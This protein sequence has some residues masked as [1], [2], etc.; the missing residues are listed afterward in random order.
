[1]S[2]P[3]ESAA[4]RE[5]PQAAP[6][7]SVARRHEGGNDA[8]ATRH[9]VANPRADRPART[10]AAAQHGC[11]KRQALTAAPP[12]SATVAALLTSTTWPPAAPLASTMWLAQQQLQQRPQRGQTRSRVQPQSQQQRLQSFVPAPPPARS[13]WIQR[14]VSTDTYPARDE[15]GR[16][17]KL[18]SHEEPPLHPSPTLEWRNKNSPR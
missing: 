10:T 2:A 3:V 5:A 1:M 7:T 15:A 11:S 8:A 4:P 12:P 16:G 9:H 18:A 17:N 13:A 14:Q 6:I